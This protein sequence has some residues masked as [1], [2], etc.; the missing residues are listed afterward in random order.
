MSN[1]CVGQYALLMSK[2][3][4]GALLVMEAHNVLRP[5][6]AFAPAGRFLGSLTHFT[7]S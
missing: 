1:I 7:K 2:H 5:K 4:S 3:A 6:L